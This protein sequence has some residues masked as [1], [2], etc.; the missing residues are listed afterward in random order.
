MDV[1]AIGGGGAPARHELPR[2]AKQRN[3]VDGYLAELPDDRKVVL[4]CRGSCVGPSSRGGVAEVAF[5]GQTQYIPSCLVRG[6]DPDLVRDLPRATAV[7][8]GA[9]APAC[10]RRHRS[11]SPG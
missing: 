1:H 2:G 7:V 8:P 5:A 6:V 9:H 4:T 10:A 11:P 3:A